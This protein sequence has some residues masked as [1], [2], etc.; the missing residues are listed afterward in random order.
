MLDH[1]EDIPRLK[2]PIAGEPAPT[3][4]LGRIE[5]FRKRE[6]LI[7]RQQLKTETVPAQNNVEDTEL[8]STNITETGVQ[9]HAA[10]SISAALEDDVGKMSS[11]EK[12]GKQFIADIF[13]RGLG[14]M[15]F[16]FQMEESRR[17]IARKEETVTFD[18]LS[19]EEQLVMIDV[20]TG[21]VNGRN[22]D[23]TS[24]LF[25]YAK[26]IGI[27]E[28]SLWTWAS[29]VFS[30]VHGKV[31]VEN[32]SSSASSSVSSAVATGRNTKEAIVLGS[33]VSVS[34]RNHNIVQQS[35]L[36][37]TPSTPKRDNTSSNHTFATPSQK[38]TNNS[39][40]PIKLH[41]YSM[42]SPQKDIISNRAPKT[43]NVFFDEEVEFGDSLIMLMIGL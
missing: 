15:K 29:Y 11:E 34:D 18:E 1:D 19:P 40:K 24:D 12:E 32:L 39:F 4:V 9:E 8:P 10:P 41:P 28:T 27:G 7:A 36:S 25:G 20:A 35:Q 37:L 33:S 31:W 43:E 13:D 26:K 17:P 21:V 2:D 3:T 22:T 30:Y 38:S 16:S 23:I 14:E 6:R 5:L 42:L